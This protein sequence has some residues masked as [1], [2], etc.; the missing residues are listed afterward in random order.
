MD[1]WLGCSALRYNLDRKISDVFW[2]IGCA[3][4][5]KHE[6]V[7]LNECKIATYYFAHLAKNHWLAKNRARLR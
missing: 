4:V 2:D 6:F 3:S 5:L 7:T 1:E